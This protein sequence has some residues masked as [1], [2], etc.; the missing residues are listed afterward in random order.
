M[1]IFGNQSAGIAYINSGTITPDVYW[2]KDA[3]GQAQGGGGLPPSNGLTTAQ[4]RDPTN[5]VS[6]DFGPNSAWTMPAGAAHPVLSW[7]NAQQQ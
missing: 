2:N 3:T 4:M 6:W 7:Q 1:N 5:F